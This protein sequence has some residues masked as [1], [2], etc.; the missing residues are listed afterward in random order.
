MHPQRFYTIFAI[1][2]IGLSFSLAW[3]RGGWTGIHFGSPA[4][5]IVIT[6][7]GLI[8][9]TFVDITN[10]PFSKNQLLI[11]GAI[12]AFCLIVMSYIVINF[13]RLRSTRSF[14][15]QLGWGYFLFLSANMA[16]IGYWFL[17]YKQQF[18][19]KEDTDPTLLDDLK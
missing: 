4:L 13:V 8:L 12:T 15:S 2:L 17:C 7:I 18:L 5:L 19:D 6:Y 1:I 16:L 10:R 11:L 14:L 9:F 3:T